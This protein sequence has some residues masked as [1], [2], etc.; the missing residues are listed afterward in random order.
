MAIGMRCSLRIELILVGL[1][2]VSFSRSALA[3]RRTLPATVQN[4]AAPLQLIGELPGSAQMRLSLGLPMRNLEALT[5]LLA[6]LYNPTSPR[7]HQYLT[8]D[9]FTEQFGPS[10]DDYQ[11]VIEFAGTNALTVRRTYRNRLLLDVEGSVGDIEKAFHVVLHV[12]KHPTEPRNFFAPDVAPSVPEGIPVLAVSGLDNLVLPHPTDLRASPVKGGVHPL[13]TGSR[14]GTFFGNDLRTA[15]VPGTTLDGTGQSVGIVAF[16]GYYTNDIAM[17]ES[18]TGFTNVAVTN[19]LLDGFNGAPGANNLEVALDIEM[20]ISMAPNL[21][22]V[23]VYE[24]D[25]SADSI[26]NQM[27][28]DNIAKQLSS[29]WTYY[30][31]PNVFQDYQE[32]K[33][34]GQVMFQASGDGGS[35]GTA[36]PEP[37]EDPDVVVVGGTVLT[38]DGGG[39]PWV[40]ETTWKGSGGGVGSGFPIPTWQQGID[41]TV[42]GGSTSKRNVPDVSIVSAQ[43]FAVGDNGGQVGLVGTSISAPLWAGFTA[44]VN[45][46]N[47]LN[48]NPPVGFLSPALYQIGLG[49]N[50]AACF[51]DITTGSN[52]NGGSPTQYF[53]VPGYDLC[54]GWGTPG[55]NLINALAPINSLRVTPVAGLGSSGANGGP[56]SPV[57]SV[58]S[59][60]NAT[61]VPL[62]WSVINTS[63]WLNVSPASGGLGS[64]AA[65]VMVNPNSVADYLPA[66]SYTANLAFNDV[67]GGTSES[68]Q[69]TLTVNPFLQNGGFEAGNFSSWTLSGAG[70]Q[71]TVVSTN[72]SFPEGIHSGAWGVEL[73]NVGLPPG[74][75]SQTIPTTVGQTYLLSFWLDST[76]NP[77]SPHKTTPNQFL[78]SWNGTVLVNQS[79]IGVI[80]WTNMQFFVT[81]SGSS[82]TLQFGF[83]DDPWAFGLD[84][85]VLQPVL[86]PSYQGVSVTNSALRFTWGAVPGLKYQAQYKTN[87]L[88]TSWI[89]SG[90]VVTAADVLTIT[91]SPMSSDPQRFYRIVLVP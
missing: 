43:V 45:Q 51:H 87:L 74:Y 53:A 71:S 75:I 29:S 60:S 63:A 19:V 2:A 21:S 47:A 7:Y 24:S 67:G 18:L 91:S 64:N 82:S 8:A 22:S 16:D 25:F 15:Y 30:F 62:S 36:P 27:A 78:A 72:G 86:P 77:N 9:E 13:G 49:P 3:D 33:A 42:N 40:S 34:Q 80:G 1:L 4:V 5:N 52:T 65:A 11:R 59:L 79:N 50:Y 14:Y 88:Q 35:Y 68:R 85:I 46:Q 28:A 32:F 6:D 61:G 10:T 56:F 73:A 54:T 83:R 20:P 41:M 38:T 44:L 23:I 17:F 12:Y 70:N 66:G 89:N 90:S 48:D 26:I 37:A 69:F 31:S 57:S 81:A 58:F 76:A 84:D 55:T 39:G